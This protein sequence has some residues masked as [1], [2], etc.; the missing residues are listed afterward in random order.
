LDVRDNT[1]QKKGEVR[2]MIELN[3]KA[4]FEMAKGSDEYNKLIKKLP[5]VFVGKEERL[6]NLIKILCMAAKKCMM[7]KKMHMGPWRKQRYMEAKWLGPCERNT[8]TTSLPIGYAER[9]KTKPKFK[10]SLLTV[11]LLEKLPTL[12]CT[13]IK[14]V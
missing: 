5:E 3:F 7:D 2:V 4:E 14:V 8:S 1:N 9:I 12:H 13:T 10:A 6:S 11:D